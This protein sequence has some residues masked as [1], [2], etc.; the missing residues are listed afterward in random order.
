VLDDVRSLLDQMHPAVAASVDDPFFKATAVGGPAAWM[1][2][3]TS[4][5]HNSVASVAGARDPKERSAHLRWGLLHAA[6]RPSKTM[7][8]RVWHRKAAPSQAAAPV[9]AAFA[10]A[11]GERTASAP[12]AH[13]HGSL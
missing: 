4:L 11:S 8:R 12:C 10:F 13:Q 5:T 7:R 1:S 6:N 9:S 2:R 3:S